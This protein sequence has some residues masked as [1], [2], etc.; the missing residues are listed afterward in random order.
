L[1]ANVPPAELLACQ[2][3][4]ASIERDLEERL[5]IAAPAAD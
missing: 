1:L 3:V 5:D 2:H 4:L